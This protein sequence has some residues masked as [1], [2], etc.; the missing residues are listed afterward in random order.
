VPTPVPAYL[1]EYGYWADSI[2]VQTGQEAL[3]GQRSAAEVAGQW[4]EYFTAA[5]KKFLEK[6]Q[7]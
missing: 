4:A 1:E 2:A 6:G 3:L 7:N 5:Q